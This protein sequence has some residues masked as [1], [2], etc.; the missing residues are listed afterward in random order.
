MYEEDKDPNSSNPLSDEVDESTFQLKVPPVPTETNLSEKIS[1][2]EPTAKQKKTFDKLISNLGIDR[3][4]NELASLKTIIAETKKETEET[5]AL[6]KDLVMA[7]KN[8]STN[9]ANPQP[10]E[11]QIEEYTSIREMPE[12]MKMG[13]IKDILMGGADLVKAWKGTT[14]QNQDLASG[15]IIMQSLA[16]A[17]QVHVDDIVSSTLNRLPPEVQ[18]KY[19][20]PPTQYPPAQPIPQRGTQG[21][22]K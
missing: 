19:I 8:A 10:Q 14:P 5:K 7:I 20:T 1:L 18:A 13:M 11:K 4:N 21:F 3:I 15:S 22:V 16:R 9:P 17:F 2:P 6:V 12:T